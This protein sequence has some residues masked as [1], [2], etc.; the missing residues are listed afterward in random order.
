MVRSGKTLGQDRDGLLEIGHCGRIG[1]SDARFRGFYV[2]ADRSRN[3]V[4]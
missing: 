1:E 3:D 4:R 2:V